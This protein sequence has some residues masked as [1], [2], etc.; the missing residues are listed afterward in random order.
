VSY[1]ITAPVEGFTGDVVGVAFVDG[2]GTTSAEG[3]LAYFHRHGYTVEQA[4]RRKRGKAAETPK[5]PDTSDPGQ[6][7]GGG[8]G[9]TGEDG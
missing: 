4:T 8:D 6:G 1:L 2:Q 9:Q 7:D 5:T 3:A